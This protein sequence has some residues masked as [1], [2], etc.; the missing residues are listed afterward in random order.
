MKKYE[1]STDPLK[2]DVLHPTVLLDEDEEQQKIFRIVG[3]EDD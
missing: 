3:G 1:S 2:K